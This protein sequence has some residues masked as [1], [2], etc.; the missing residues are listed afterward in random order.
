[1]TYCCERVRAG[2]VRANFTPRAQK[3]SASAPNAGNRSV[4]AIYASISL[5][6]G[7]PL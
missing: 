1:M 2:C 3:C 6:V 4:P 7:G 5:S